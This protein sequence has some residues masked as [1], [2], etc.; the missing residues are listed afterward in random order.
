MINIIYLI[1][2][3]K[4][5]FMNNA[6]NNFTFGYFSSVGWL[7]VYVLLPLFIMGKERE[8]HSYWDIPMAAQIIS[9]INAY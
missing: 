8:K 3:G 2:T 1:A 4:N 9:V 7:M 5:I 6:L